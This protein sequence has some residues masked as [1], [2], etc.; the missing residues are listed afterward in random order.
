MQK[1]RV[2]SDSERNLRSTFKIVKTA[3]LLPSAFPDLSYLQRCI[4]SDHI[5]IDDVSAFNRK[6]SVHR[7]KIRTPQGVHWIYLPVHTDDRKLP[8]HQ[9]RLD[10]TTDWITPLWRAIEY[11]YRNSIYFEHYEPE[12]HADLVHISTSQNYTDAT[13]YLNQ[14]LWSYLELPASSLPTNYLSQEFDPEARLT[15]LISTQD[16]IYEA[17]SKNYQSYSRSAISPSDENLPPYRQHFGGFE[18]ECCLLDLLFEEGPESWR[19]IEK[20]H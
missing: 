20:L 8:L 11:N 7:G 5:V 16:V 19:I 2:M 14:K 13:R 12:I 15:Q 4:T 6:S 9:A 1:T 10:F 18:P 3:L 17:N